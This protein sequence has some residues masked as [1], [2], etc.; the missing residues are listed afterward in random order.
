MSKKEAIAS[1]IVVTST[2]FLIQ[3][4]FVYY[5]IRCHSLLF[6]LGANY[7]IKL[8]NDSILDCSIF[9]KHVP[10]SL[11]E[12]ILPEDLIQFDL[13]DFDSILG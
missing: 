8:P 2:L 7:R 10:I 1:G 3:F 6:D 11:G 5:L 13:F 9:Y 4:L 12:S